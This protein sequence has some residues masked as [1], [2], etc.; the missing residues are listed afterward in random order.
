MDFFWGLTFRSTFNYIGYTG[1]ENEAEDYF[2][3]NLSLGK[4]F[5]KNEAA[6]IKIEAFDVLRQNRSFTHQTG[7]NYYDYVSS[8]VLQPYAMI[9]FVYTIRQ[10]KK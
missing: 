2:L 7:S 3:W 4:K 8:N 5:L 6:E 10:L 1:L 9:S